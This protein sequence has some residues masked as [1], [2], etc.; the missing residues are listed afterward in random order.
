[1]IVAFNKAYCFS[2]SVVCDVPATLDNR[3]YIGEGIIVGYSGNYTI[4]GIEGEFGLMKIAIT[5]LRYPK[6][7]T[8]T[9]FISLFSLGSLCETIGTPV[10]YLKSQYQLNSHISFVAHKSVIF[11]D[12]IAH[13]SV[14]VCGNIFVGNMSERE[15]FDYKTARTIPPLSERIEDQLDLEYETEDWLGDI[16]LREVHRILKNIVSRMTVPEHYQVYLDLIEINSTKSKELRY[17]LLRRLIWS[18]YILN[19]DFITKQPISKRHKSDL[20]K[21]HK[22]INEK[23]PPL[24]Y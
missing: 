22:L 5:N 3:Y 13:I 20:I 4:G 1:M 16:D 10:E 24:Y 18:R 2:C 14:G 12:S 7:K 11:R 21:E 6:L 19:E 17:Y 9:I 23:W 15:R 8:D